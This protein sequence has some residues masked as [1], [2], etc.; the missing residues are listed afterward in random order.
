MKKSLKSVFG[1]YPTWKEAENGVDELHRAGF[2]ERNISVLVRAREIERDEMAPEEHTQG[3]KGL[4]YGAAGGALLGGG[5]GWVLGLGALVIPG[6]GPML[7][8]GPIL[9]ALAGI[10]M[11]SA[12]GG[13][14]G[15]FVGV[16]FPEHKANFLQDRLK[17]GGILV[18]VHTETLELRDS[19]LRILELSGAE[20]ISS[21]DRED[22]RV[23]A[24]DISPSFEIPPG[25]PKDDFISRKQF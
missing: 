13:I 8:F 20:E 23:L 2:S 17:E 7:A 18:A 19:A 9:S 10:G 25:S 21:S 16:G 22:F 1:I 6:I 5:L 14:A 15:A 24:E 3:S 4:V 11:G 12:A